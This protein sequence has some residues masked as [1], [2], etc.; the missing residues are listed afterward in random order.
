MYFWTHGALAGREFMEKSELDFAQLCSR[1]IHE[2][3]IDQGFE[4]RIRTRR[5]FLQSRISLWSKVSR[6]HICLC[7]K[8]NTQQAW[9]LDLQKNKCTINLFRSN[10]PPV[11]GMAIHSCYAPLRRPYEYWPKVARQQKPIYTITDL[12]IAALF[13]SRKRNEIS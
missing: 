2:M 3:I 10:H 9:I 13:L 12:F 7:R 4:N 11:H 5:C 6:K 1:P 8:H